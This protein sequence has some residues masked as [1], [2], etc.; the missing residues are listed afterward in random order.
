VFGDDLADDGVMSGLYIPLKDDEGV[1][2]ILVLESAHADFASP[3][4]QELATILANQ[5]TVAMRNAQLYNQVPLA[6]ALGA[7]HARKEAL[8]A[9]PRQR[10]IAWAIAAVVVL[11][12]VTLIRWPLRVS[13]EAPLFR[14]NA[15][16]DVRP[17][18]DGIVERVLVREGTRVERGAPIVQLRDAE[19]RSEYE[20]A[21]A[22]VSAA[23]RSAA[24]AASRGDAAL[25]RLEHM[26]ADVLRREAAVREDRFRSATVR[27]P[28]SGVVL[29]PRP[30][31]RVGSWAEAG[32]TVVV[33]G[34]TDTLELDFGVD[35]RDVGRVHVGQE[36]RLRVDAFPQRTFTGFVSGVADVALDSAGIVMFPVRA[37]VPN[38]DG[39][40]RSG[41]S[42]HA[43]V[44]TGPSSLAGRVLREP[45]R[46]LRLLWWRMWS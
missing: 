30:E 18:T 42:P 44:L 35:Q 19:L 13:A 3:R 4:Q 34:R 14:P 41:M 38:A 43:R 11:G 10:R 9:L 24:A 25:E 16:A 37:V 36:V 39:S 23:E 40:L 26:R 31:D 32:S 8:L 22:A 27:A 33:L 7:L 28:V 5:A 15:R 1:V 20:A 12:A 17:L 45:M 46:R 6:D 21:L 2:G 29:T